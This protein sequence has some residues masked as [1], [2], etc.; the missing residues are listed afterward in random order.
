MIH[1]VSPD[2]DLKIGG[3]LRWPLALEPGG[4]RLSL[5]ACSNLRGSSEVLLSPESRSQSRSRSQ[6]GV[7]SPSLAV[8]RV[9]CSVDLGLQGPWSSRILSPSDPGEVQTLVPCNAREVAVRFAPDVLGRTTSKGTLDER[10]TFSVT[11][12]I[13]QR[14]GP[15]RAWVV[16]AM[17]SA[18]SAWQTSRISR[19]GSPIF[20]RGSTVTPPDRNVS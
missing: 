12:P 5:G 13:I 16:I 2:R 15:T 6:L 7:N 17:R 8:S 1:A 14:V 20:I 10:R 4:C 11:L 3:N 18:F 9:D 19:A